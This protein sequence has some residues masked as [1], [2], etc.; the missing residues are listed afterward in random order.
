MR[1]QVHTATGLLAALLLGTAGMFLPVKASAQTSGIETVTVTAERRAENLQTV[2]I[3]MTVV[4][5]EQMDSQN[6][7]T[8]SD[9]VRAVPSLTVSDEGVYQI[10]SIGTEGFGRS[11]EQSV[12]VVMDGVVLGRGLTNQMY[13]L[14]HVEVLSG[15][16]GTL[17]GKNATAGVVNIVTQAPVIGQ[18]EG[19]GHIDVGNQDYVHS[20]AVANIPINDT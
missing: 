6:I 20:Y 13:D 11:A 14:D 5:K 1:V 3:T 9:L 10:R 17:F 7:V 4:T 19:L 8:T 16:Q 12:S 15:P 18:F 2:P